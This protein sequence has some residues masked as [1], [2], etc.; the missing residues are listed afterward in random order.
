MPP[1]RTLTLACLLA[2]APHAL[3]QPDIPV[4]PAALVSPALARADN[5]RDFGVS[6]ASDHAG[7][8][9]ACWATDRTLADGQVSRMV[10]STSGNDGVTWTT[11]ITPPT[12]DFA[13]QGVPT[14][15]RLSTNGAGRW[16][17]AWTMAPAATSLSVFIS[18]SDDNGATW[19]PA[20][21]LAA[22]PG[23]NSSVVLC[24]DALGRWVAA[25][26]SRDLGGPGTG[27]LY[28]VATS[29][30]NGQTWS[31]PRA[32]ADFGPGSGS[33]P[34]HGLATDRHG[35]CVLTLSYDN[36]PDD[37]GVRALVSDD[38]GQTFSAPITLVS[39]PQDNQD[40]YYNAAVDTDGQGGWVV[41]WSASLAPTEDDA[42][43]YNI[44][45]SRSIDN[46]STWSAPIR[47]NT[48]FLNQYGEWDF[49][50]Q[51]AFDGLG[52]CVVT[53]EVWS[54]VQPTRFDIWTARSADRG[55]TWLPS[56]RISSTT[57]SGAFDTDPLI[58]RGQSERLLITWN[59][60]NRLPGSFSTDSDIAMRSTADGGAT[61]TPIAPL[62]PTGPADGRGADQNPAIAL[63]ARS[64]GLM[65]WRTD[66]DLGFNAAHD[67][68]LVISTTADAGRT[69][70]TPHPLAPNSL[71]DTI[72]DSAAHIAGNGSGTWMV[73][74]S[75]QQLTR[76]R[77]AALVSR[78]LDDGATWSTP[79][80]LSPDPTGQWT[81][82]SPS[83]VHLG[84]TR[85]LTAWSTDNW[86]D[87]SIGFD[88]DLLYCTTD[89]NGQTWSPAQILNS[90]A[91]T[92]VPNDIR[93]SVVAGSGGTVIAAFNRNVPGNIAV[94]ISRDNAATWQPP[95]YAVPDGGSR[96]PLSLATD[97]SG[98]WIICWRETAPST[99]TLLI[100]R[101]VD[102]GQ[103][104]SQPTIVPVAPTGNQRLTDPAI[105][106]DRAGTWIISTNHTNQL[107]TLR[108]IDAG[109][110]WSPVRVH[111][112][113]PTA[114]AAIACTTGAPS[115]AWVMAWPSNNP[116][117]PAGND[118]DLYY[119]AFTIDDCNNNGRAD[120]LDITTFAAPDCNHNMIPDTCDI[121]AGR[122]ADC[123]ADGLLD[124]CELAAGEPD[125]NRDGIPDACQCLA[126]ADHDGDAS[127]Q[128]LLVFLQGW[129]GRTSIGDFNADNTWTTEDIFAFLTAYFTGCA[130]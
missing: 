99:D 126:D 98:N 49:Q 84:G 19:S 31:P 54:Y 128:D 53:W 115:S 71:T 105:A 109:Q 42:G 88:F 12:F 55:A 63:D 96:G 83:V 112:S 57:V 70:S 48:N 51:V 23:A 72:E 35:R 32:L 81:I 80:V 4:P 29:A 87:G 106:T 56:I 104:W 44:Y 9:V 58:V 116:P 14:E 102:D 66:G 86:L 30:D 100:V 2:L 16:I 17:A 113:I 123:D 8:M 7:H 21:V 46:G 73:A 43:F 85:W 69:W 111:G 77:N 24:G 92:D 61:F 127:L 93:L 26:R 52:R 108:S 10:F 40:V 78:S 6:I 37:E 119:T 94:I 75:G 90:D 65:L 101:S 33:P 79:T 130:P 95:S 3:A 68:D 91:E 27:R 5:S 25:W 129:F 15:V 67:L 59:S 125:V 64:R 36:F 20:R 62:D 76:V 121:A 114:A 122:A 50:P 118:P 13:A 74:W 28:A 60:Q 11:P 47:V 89:D 41:T 103:T 45:S 82:D 1:R 38:M 97:G 120:A 18:S 34:P 107:A 117:G 22:T 110:T 124:S 39:S